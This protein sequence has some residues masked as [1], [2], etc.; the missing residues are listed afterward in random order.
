MRK[1]A[2]FPGSFDPITKGHLDIVSRGLALFDEIVV[3][4]GINAN[5]TYMFTVEQRMKFIRDAFTHL[6]QV[7]VTSF[8]GLTVDQC[9]TIGAQYILRGLR[10]PADFE[11][12]KAIAQMNRAMVPKV[13]TVF[14]LTSPELSAISSS[15]IRDIYRNGGDVTQFLPERVSLS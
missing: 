10:N 7:K 1:V 5:K 12:E 15:I 9:E 3:G 6:P 13:E 14:L 11:F 8:V 2:L 4:V